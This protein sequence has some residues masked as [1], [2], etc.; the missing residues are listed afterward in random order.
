MSWPLQ[1]KRRRHGRKSRGV[2][3]LR[4]H[5]NLLLAQSCWSPEI[6]RSGGEAEGIGLR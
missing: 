1:E 6:G 5:G 3:W 4:E 2:E